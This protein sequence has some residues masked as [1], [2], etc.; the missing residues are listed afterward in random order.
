MTMITTSKFMART[1][2]SRATIWRYRKKF[3]EF[4]KPVIL[5]P[6][7]IRWIEEDVDRWIEALR[8]VA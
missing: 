2:L 4:P 8:K 7:T 1:G 5:S 6:S 3:P